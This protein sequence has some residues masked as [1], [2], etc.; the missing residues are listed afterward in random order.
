[1]PSKQAVAAR[2]QVQRRL[3]DQ[4]Q[5]RPDRAGEHDEQSGAGQDHPQ[6]GAGGDVPAAGPDRLADV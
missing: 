5:Q 2:A 3:G 4:R 1:M 6:H